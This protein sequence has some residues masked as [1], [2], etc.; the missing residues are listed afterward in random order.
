[1]S[2]VL[3]PSNPGSGAKPAVVASSGST[4]KPAKHTRARGWCFTWNNFPPEWQVSLDQLPVEYLVCGKEKAPTTGT[5][6]LQGYM[7]FSNARTLSSL[8]RTLPGVHLLPA[9]GTGA[10]NRAYCTKGEDY[11]ERGVC[12]GDSKS[13]GAQENSRWDHAL[14]MARDG[15]LEAIPS[16]IV[17]R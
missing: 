3:E 6:H 15:T 12:P 13:G 10:Q 4:S 1:M 2:D 16:D 11:I 5:P 9:R 8:C 14:A 7:W 17:I